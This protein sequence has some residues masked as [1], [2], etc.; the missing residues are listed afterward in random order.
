MYVSSYMD[1]G[2]R[3]HVFIYVLHCHPL[4]PLA[5]CM[6]HRVQK[7]PSKHKGSILPVTEPQSRIFCSVPDGQP[8]VLSSALENMKIFCRVYHIIFP[9]QI[10]FR[11]END[12]T[13]LVQKLSYPL[14]IEPRS[15]RLTIRQ[16]T[17]YSRLQPKVT[18]YI[19]LPAARTALE[20]RPEGAGCST[21]S[22]VHEPRPTVR[23]QGKLHKVISTAN[24]HPLG[25]WRLLV[26]QH[27]LILQ[28]T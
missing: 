12:V 6:L 20:V 11:G 25:S 5:D 28:S 27:T 7:G 1:S 3:Y 17:K 19:L 22:S 16:P 24:F 8:N 2:V 21:Q 15:V 4:R 14:T 23:R 9:W 13:D 10:Y 18:S 26:W